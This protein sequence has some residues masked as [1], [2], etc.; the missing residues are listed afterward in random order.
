[1]TSNLKLPTVEEACLARESG[2]QLAAAIGQSGVVRVQVNDDLA[3]I[4]VPVSAMRL[5]V[6]GL[7]HMAAGDAVE[8]RSFPADLTIPQAA[9][10]LHVSPAYV[11]ELRDRGELAFREVRGRMRVQ[12]AEVLVYLETDRVLRKSAVD[13]LT[14][15]S[16]ETSQGY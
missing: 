16:Q 13:E 9:E 5:L 15:F 2:R 11:R 3:E 8:L 4:S 12:L 1:M 10:I 14:R 6:A 7:A